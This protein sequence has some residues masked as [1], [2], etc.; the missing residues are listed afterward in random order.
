MIK[1]SDDSIPTMA[2][3]LRADL[4]HRRFLFPAQPSLVLTEATDQDGNALED[5]EKHYLDEIEMTVEET[6]AIVAQ[7]TRTGRVHLGLPGEI[8]SAM[9]RTYES[10]GMRTP[11]KDRWVAIMLMNW[12]A[13]QAT[14]TKIDQKEEA[15]AGMSLASAIYG[16]QPAHI[17][18]SMM[19]MKR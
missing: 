13:H 8:N 17:A 6:T 18:R 12:A 3:Q 10:Y 2:E 7:S 4:D 19:R 5:L 1:F 14:H 15:D 11:R 9:A 16:Q